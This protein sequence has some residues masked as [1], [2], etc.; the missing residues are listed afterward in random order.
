MDHYQNNISSKNI[1]SNEEVP[2]IHFN[3]LLNSE[4]NKFKIIN[5]NYEEKETPST[6]INDN[7]NK[8]K[9]EENHRRSK[10]DFEGRTFNC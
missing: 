4:N 5:V 3:P 8:N 6:K 9:K 1:E 7:K 2:L 10:K